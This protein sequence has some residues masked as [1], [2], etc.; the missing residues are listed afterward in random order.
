M[1]NPKSNVNNSSNPKE[2]K[3]YELDACNQFLFIISNSRFS[4]L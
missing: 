1:Q 3:F 4:I 2:D